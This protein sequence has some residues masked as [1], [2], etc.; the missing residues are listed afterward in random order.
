M[1]WLTLYFCAG[2]IFAHFFK[3]Y[4]W[5]L[6]S[7]GL[8]L[9]VICTIF[10][11]KDLIFKRF[12]SCLIF[13]CGAVLLTNTYILSKTHI[14]KFVSYKNDTVFT[15][16]GFVNS[17]PQLKDNQVSFLLAV[18]ELEFNRAHYKSCG[19]ILVHLKE[20]KEG[21]EGPE[22]DSHEMR[23]CHLRY[24]EAL[25]LRGTMHKPFKLYSDRIA[26][27]MRVNMPGCVIRLNRNCGNPVL[28]FAYFL[29]GKI[30]EVIYQRLSKLAAGIANAMILGEER[31]I[32]VA[33]YDAMAK[34]GTVHILVVSGFNVG[35]VAFIIIL[36]FKVL[37]VP[38]KLRYLLAIPCLIIYCL[39]TGAQAP[40]ARATI[41]AIFFLTGFLLK[42]EPDI[43]NSFSLA[44]L[45]ILLI[46]PRE[47]F[48]ISFQ[49]SF[50]SVAAII[51]LDP[52]LNAFFKTECIKLKLLRLIT[53]GALVSLSA[54]VATLGLIAYNFRFLSPVTVL[55]N[56]FIVPL[57][58]LITLSGF[59]LVIISI[60][61][62]VWAGFF[63]RAIE[64]LVV[65]LLSVNNQLVQ[66]PLAYLHW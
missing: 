36:L 4:F 64:F 21:E 59:S 48:S 34:S 56:I 55:A 53:E 37:R 60:I 35:I 54:W 31:G 43:R 32:P 13:I 38:R 20:I 18:Q 11:K 66:F 1:S 7:L 39:A 19:E 29:K 40:V 3:V 25:I 44:A 10:I 28:R 12:S 51:F 61:F 45:F 14:S 22:G 58:T 6:Y 42:R 9:L 46:N 24:G 47:V 8:A 50:A 23:D 2:I 41:M 63:A 57:A 62:P 49:L 26:A 33:V 65:V 17:Q 52:K 16:K 15:V 5:P 30:E 27:I